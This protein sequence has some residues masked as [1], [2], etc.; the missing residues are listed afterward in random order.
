MPAP[1]NGR[2]RQ[3]SYGT[4]FTLGRAPRFEAFRNI[5][6]LPKPTKTIYAVELVEGTA[7]DDRNGFVSADHVHP[8]AWT[9]AVPGD[10]GDAVVGAQVEIEQHSGKANYAFLDGHA[11]TLTR[12]QTILNVGGFVANWEHNQYWPQIAR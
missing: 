2:L 4:P 11:E 12:E 3:V 8:E 5:D 10:A 1:T 9:T 6:M 7:T